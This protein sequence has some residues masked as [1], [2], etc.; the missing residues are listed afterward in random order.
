MTKFNF[1]T[2]TPE[3][4]WHY[5]GMLEQRHVDQLFLRP[6]AEAVSDVES[7][8]DEALNSLPAEDFLSDISHL[9]RRL[10]TDPGLTKAKMKGALGNIL[11]ELEELTLDLNQSTEYA[12]EKIKSAKNILNGECN[13][14]N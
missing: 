3:E 14:H 12:A 13:D 7:E 11:N 10:V 2:L 1:E 5:N 9:I 6:T 8:L 4:A